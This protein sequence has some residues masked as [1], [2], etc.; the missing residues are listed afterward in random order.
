MLLAVNIGNT[1]IR[2]GVFD[3]NNCDVSWTINTKPLKTTDELFALFS[4]MYEQY[5]INE[6]SIKQIVIGSVV[7]NLT[8]S[9]SKALRRI[10]TISPKIV[11]RNTFSQVK[12]TSNQ[13]G[14]D[15]YANAVSAHEQ[16]QGKKL[17][18][19][20]GTALT[21]IAIDEKGNVLG[22]IIAPGIITSLNSLIG[23]TAQLPEIEFKK[24]K[25]VLGNDTVSC[26]QSGMVFGFLG[27]V[28]GLIDRV[29]NEYGNDFFVISTGGMGSIYAPL[30]DKIDL[31][32]KL[33]TLKGL[34]HLYDLSENLQ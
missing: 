14:T 31:N 26:M 29:K 6:S 24:P 1:N 33:H 17:I 21:L 8:Q 28:E 3:G 34:K 10:H 32:D 15:L 2:F 23:N 25:N 13:M 22:V 19:D 30:T 5:S 20:F 18:I 12:H 4:T 9:V 7:P 16:Y 11:D 27:M